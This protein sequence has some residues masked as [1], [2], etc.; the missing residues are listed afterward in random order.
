MTAAPA[1]RFLRVRS[2]YAAEVECV[3]CGRTFVV[4]RDGEDGSAW[5]PKHRCLEESEEE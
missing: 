1:S 3:E 4:D 5:T 2:S